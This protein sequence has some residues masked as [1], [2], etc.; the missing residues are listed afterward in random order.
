MRGAWQCSRRQRQPQ[1]DGSLMREAKL[2]HGQGR[3]CV[4]RGTLCTQQGARH[5]AREWFQRS[6]TASPTT[7]SPRLLN[8]AR[9]FGGSSTPD[10]SHAEHAPLSVND[11]GLLYGRRSPLAW[12]T[13]CP[14]GLMDKASDSGSGDCEFDSRRGYF[15]CPDFTGTHET[16]GVISEWW[17]AKQS[18]APALSLTEA[19]SPHSDS[20]QV[21]ALRR[22]VFNSR[23]VGPSSWGLGG[24]PPPKIK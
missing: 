6:P 7:W 19:N 24:A 12:D 13:R 11:N 17:P 15:V 18:R 2:G 3:S 23:S 10:A 5:G 22:S 1:N 14:R 21:S 16:K 20:T 8:D 4:R 9:Q